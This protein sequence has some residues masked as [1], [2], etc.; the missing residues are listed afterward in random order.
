MGT[1]RRRDASPPILR[2]RRGWL[3]ALLVLPVALSACATQPVTDVAR[4][5]H[6]EYEI[7]LTIALVMFVLVGTTILAFVVRFR[8]RRGDPSPA[9]SGPTDDR[10]L[11]TAFWLV[12]VLI[13]LF[14]LANEMVALGKIDARHPHPLRVDVEG[15]QWQW[16]FTYPTY[17]LSDGS[18][19]SFQG[20]SGMHPVRPVL[21]L[22][23][24]RPI[25]IH[26]TAGD[27]LHAFFV[28]DF[29]FQRMA[30]P[31]RVG[32]FSFTPDRTG[33]FQGACTELCGLYHSKMLFTVKVLPPGAFATYMR[34]QVTAANHAKA[35]CRT[36]PGG[37]ARLVASGI[38]FDTNCL[39]V[40]ANA[41]VKI[42][43][44]NRDAGVA[45]NV[46]ILQ[47]NTILF[48]GAIVTGPKAITYTVHPIPP[49]TYT[50]RCEIHPTQMV[51]TFKVG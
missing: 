21:A 6:R 5:I 25:E 10:R 7:T 32:V 47:G 50:F 17:R 36:A 16:R 24:G 29:L 38:A 39:Q 26:L 34:G 20:K 15:F 51:G 9:G 8:H 23:L 41:P 46:Q 42:A 3:S 37:V 12:P 22:P 43:F 14:F 1:G 31:G 40:A 11:Q 48:T 2:R 28:P 44:G 30:I 49:G 33:T 4:E 27:V 35:A 18:A 45:H 13:V 19:L